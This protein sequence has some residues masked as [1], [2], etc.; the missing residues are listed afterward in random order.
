MTEF[1]CIDLG[2]EEIENDG[3]PWEHFQDAVEEHWD[4]DHDGDDEELVPEDEE[5]DG[6]KSDPEEEELEIVTGGTQ[7]F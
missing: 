7:D 6:P 2:M 3:R 1:L 4:A 5:M